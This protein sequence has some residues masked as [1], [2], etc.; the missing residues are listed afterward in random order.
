MIAVGD[1][2]LRIKKPALWL[3]VSNLSGHELIMGRV[4]NSQGSQAVS[5]GEHWKES[6]P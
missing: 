1:A 3:S 6:R 4:E 2:F 5:V